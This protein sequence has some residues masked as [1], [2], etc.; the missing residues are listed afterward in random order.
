M[1]WFIV[2]YVRLKPQIKELKRT[3]LCDP[4]CLLIFAFTAPGVLFELVLIQL[5][6]P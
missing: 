5:F 4:K 1:S 6:H 2:V 3:V